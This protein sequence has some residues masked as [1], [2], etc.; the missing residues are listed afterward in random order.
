MLRAA[1]TPLG[2]VRKAKT[3]AMVSI[4]TPAE[5]VIVRGADAAIAR[6]VHD[7]LRAAGGIIKLSFRYGT[8]G[9]AAYRRGGLSIS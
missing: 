4:R 1:A 8:D 7:D 5:L 2:Q 6:A 9:E 3:A